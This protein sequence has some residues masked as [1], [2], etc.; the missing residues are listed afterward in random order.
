[1]EFGDSLRVAEHKERH[2]CSVICGAPT[3]RKGLRWDRVNRPK[4]SIIIN[5]AEFEKKKNV[6][7]M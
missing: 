5:I 3:N 4:L 2:Y 6:Y 7:Y 1:M